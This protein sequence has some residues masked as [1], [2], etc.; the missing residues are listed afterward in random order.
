MVLVYALLTGL[1]VVGFTLLSEAASYGFERVRTFGTLGP[2]LTLVWTPALTVAVLWWTRR[3]VPAAMGS[4]IPQV[5][6]ALDD[7]VDAAQPRLAG[8]AAGIAAQDRAGVGG[9][10]AGCRSAAKVRRCRSAR[11]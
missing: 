7:G 3:F 9:L 2:W 5:V 4:G 8:R 6:A 1:V 10:L 11:V